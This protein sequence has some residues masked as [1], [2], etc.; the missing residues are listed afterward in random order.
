MPIAPRF[1]IPDVRELALQIK[2]APEKIRLKQIKTVEQLLCE[3]ENETL[4]PFDYLVFRIT[5]YKGDALVQSML[6]GSAL[7]GDLVSLIAEVSW[8]LELPDEGMLTIDESA[9]FLQ[10]SLKGY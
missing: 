6:L 5:K 9:S 7:K 10:V 3:I 1:H 2:R 4:Y 8:T